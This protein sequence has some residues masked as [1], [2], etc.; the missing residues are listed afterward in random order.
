M[1]NIFLY[2]I[3]SQVSDPDSINSSEDDC[4]DPDKIYFLDFEHNF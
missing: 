1:K 3:S 2:N 4:D